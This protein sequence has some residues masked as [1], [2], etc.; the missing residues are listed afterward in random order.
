MQQ[1]DL[2]KFI[3]GNRD[4]FDDAR[5]SLKLWADIERELEQ[6]KAT[7][8]VPIRRKTSWYQIAAAVLVLLTVGGIGGHYLGRQSIQPTDTMALIEQV[9]PDFVEMEQYYNQQIQQ[10]YAQLTTYQSDPELDAD[11]AQID[12]AMDELRAELENVPPGRE[13]QVVQELIA[14]YRIKLQILERV[15]ESIQSADDI[16]PNNSNSNETS[17]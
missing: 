13:E 9:A 14:T 3:Q 11:L 6:E 7:P 17:I 8:V 4:A 12:E 15:L 10:R 1:N 16:T 2:E 5:P